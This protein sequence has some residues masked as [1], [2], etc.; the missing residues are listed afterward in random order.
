MVESKLFCRN[1][2][3]I[4]QAIN[5]SANDSTTTVPHDEDNKIAQSYENLSQTVSINGGVDIET[6]GTISTNHTK[7]QI[8]NIVWSDIDSTILF[9]RI[10]KLIY[11]PE[12]LTDSQLQ[13][14]TK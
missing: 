6:T 10:N 5:S 2:R 4:R 14:L 8:G 12:R 9:G 13:N 1:S 7:L 11:Y 3:T